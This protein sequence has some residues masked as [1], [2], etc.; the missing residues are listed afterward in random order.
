MQ[1]TTQS[2]ETFVRRFASASKPELQQCVREL[3]AMA[4]DNDQTDAVRGVA[5]GLGG[6]ARSRVRL[7]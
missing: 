6:I 5:K 4:T 7:F 3:K 2:T 1:L